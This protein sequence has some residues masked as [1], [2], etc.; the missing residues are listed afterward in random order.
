MEHESEHASPRIFGDPSPGRRSRPPSADP[1]DVSALAT[2][3][4]R[5]LRPDESAE[6]IRRGRER[7]PEFTLDRSIARTLA[8]F[9]SA[10]ASD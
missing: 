6:L 10:L 2:A 3:M 4:E 5:A 9:E 7:L 8:L 1:F